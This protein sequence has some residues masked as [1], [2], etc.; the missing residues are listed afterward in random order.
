MN[1][2]AIST[3]KILRKFQEP[4]ERFHVADSNEHKKQAQYVHLRMHCACFF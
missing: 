4:L 2:T 1:Q 3:T